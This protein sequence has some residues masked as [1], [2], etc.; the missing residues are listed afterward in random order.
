MITCQTVYVKTK[1]IPRAT[2]TYTV[3]LLDCIMTVVSNWHTYLPQKCISRSYICKWGVHKWLTEDEVHKGIYDP[4]EV[5]SKLR[6]KVPQVLDTHSV[7]N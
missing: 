5:L 4:H 1:M 2:I 7:C 6:T 3:I